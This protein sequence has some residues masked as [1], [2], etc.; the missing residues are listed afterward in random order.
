MNKVLKQ[1]LGVDV[2]QR[3]LVIT[4]G[5]LTHCLSVELY[6]HEILPNNQNGFKSLLKWMQS[7]LIRQFVFKLLWKQPVFII[8][9]LLTF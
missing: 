4:L 1:V 8:R 2:D 7:K 5:R 9:S 3:N 6:A